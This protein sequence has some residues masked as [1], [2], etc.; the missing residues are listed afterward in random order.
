MIAEISRYG[1]ALG[2]QMVVK[3]LTALNS[4]FERGILSKEHVT[5][6]DDPV[7]QRMSEGYHFFSSWCEDV[8]LNGQ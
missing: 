6:G 2:D 1:D 8:I 3:F 7:L 5:S 4:M